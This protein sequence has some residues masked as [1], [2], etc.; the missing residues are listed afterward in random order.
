[1]TSPEATASLNRL[2]GLLDANEEARAL[3]KAE[4]ERA[5]GLA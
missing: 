4:E 1:M 3:P 2:T 5:A